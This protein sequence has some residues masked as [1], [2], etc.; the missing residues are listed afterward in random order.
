MVVEKGLEST[1]LITVPILSFPP[2]WG[3]VQLEVGIV[4]I[5]GL[6][7]LRSMMGGMHMG[8]ATLGFDIV[9]V[10]GAGH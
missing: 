10:M 2:A 7:T 6:V 3:S 1:V 9:L 4:N 5:V 8:S